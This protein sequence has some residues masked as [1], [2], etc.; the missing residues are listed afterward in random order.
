MFGFTN[1]EYFQA[2]WQNSF[3]FTINKFLTANL[4][5]DMRYDTSAMP[6]EDSKWHKFQLKELISLGFT[7]TL[8]H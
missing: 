8:S 6:L 2:D 3:M 5:V 4:N 7:Y 1:Y